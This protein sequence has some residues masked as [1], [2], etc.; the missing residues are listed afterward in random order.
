[1]DHLRHGRRPDGAADAA[2]RRP[3]GLVAP[4]VTAKMISTFDQFSGGRIAVNLIAGGGTEEL[5]AD[6]LFH[7]HDERYEMMDETVSLMKRVWT[8]DAP[9]D[10]EGRVSSRSW[11]R[12]CAPTPP[13]SPTPASTSAGS[14]TPPSR[15]APGTP[16]CTSTGA[17]RRRT[18]PP[19]SAT[20]GPGR[21]PRPVGPAPVRDAAPGDRARHGGRGLAGG[22]GA[23]RRSERR[24][25]PADRR[26]VGAVRV[27]PG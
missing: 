17:T 18:S 2:R 10:H 14:P 6:G 7:T 21:G 9:V 19:A 27:E 3:A 11:V 5:G 16:T 23:D 22:G 20:P 24:P 25:A 1:M 8:E 13:S 26:H 15:C 12:P 4:T